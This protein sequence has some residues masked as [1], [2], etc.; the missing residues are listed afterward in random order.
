M[1]SDITCPLC[2]GPTEEH[3]AY[4]DLACP[5]CG[6]SAPPSVMERIRTLATNGRI[7][8]EMRAQ[9]AA[10]TGCAN[11]DERLKDSNAWLGKLEAAER[12]LAQL[13]QFADRV[14]TV[15][16]EATGPHPVMPADDALTLI[17]RELFARRV[18]VE[19][20]KRDYT[21]VARVVGVA[22]EAEGHDVQPGP[23]DAIV[24]QVRELQR[25]SDALIEIELKQPAHALAD[26]TRVWRMNCECG[27]SAC[28]IL[29]E[30]LPDREPHGGDHG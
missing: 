14:V 16:D 26:A 3:E 6:L 20:L 15:A 5:A 30:V 4:R 7:V 8:D 21:E 22:Y 1:A 11:C 24:A 27:C 10:S 13:K 18:E 2:N 29:D 23:L 12:E 25:R 28:E 9:R 17:E 19:R